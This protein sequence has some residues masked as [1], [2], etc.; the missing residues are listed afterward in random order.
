VKRKNLKTRKVDYVTYDESY[1]H[2]LEPRMKQLCFM[3][4]SKNISLRM[5]KNKVFEIVQDSTVTG[6]FGWFVNTVEN[7]ESKKKLYFLCKNSVSKANRT[8]VERPVKAE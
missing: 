2:R 8:I 5:M 7:I 4:L 1:C 6:K 3:S